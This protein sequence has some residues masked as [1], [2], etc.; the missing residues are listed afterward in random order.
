MSLV[1]L[2]IATIL[3]VV[4]TVVVVN[5]FVA[6]RA[7]EVVEVNVWFSEQMS[8][9][10]PQP[11]APEYV[12]AIRNIMDNDSDLWWQLGRGHEMVAHEPYHQ[13]AIDIGHYLHAFG[14]LGA[15]QSL[16]CPSI[17]YG[18]FEGDNAPLFQVWIEFRYRSETVWVFTGE[19]DPIKIVRFSDFRVNHP[20][21]T[22]C[23]PIY[24]VHDGL[25][26]NI[27]IDE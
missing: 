25:D 13:Q 17:Y 2:G 12:T 1:T 24:F 5:H 14:P 8:I 23:H 7:H 15:Y 21:L 6:R 4:A 22:L 9:Y 10:P 18:V 16:Y 20:G 3:I 11:L 19:V 26:A 27:N